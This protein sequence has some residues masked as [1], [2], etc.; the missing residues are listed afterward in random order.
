ME[1]PD[2]RLH[3]PAALRNRDPIL[4][5][6]Q[7]HLP[8]QGHLLE[9][10]SGS[11]EH[12]IY[13]ARALPNYIIQP[14]DQDP[15]ARASIEAWIAASGVPNALPPLA[16]DAAAPNWTSALGNWTPTAILC[17]NMIHISP[18]EATEG[19]FKGAALLL[20]PGQFLFTY[21]PYK[22]EGQHTSESNAR[23]D[24]DLRRENPRWGIRDLES[25]TACAK[26]HGFG[27][28][29]VTQMPANNLTLTFRRL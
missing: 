4:A 18:W 23:F 20:S 11:G 10:A 26:E 2:A 24:A 6:L 9:I 16:L 25:V 13:F 3:A 19:L 1:V 7:A 27:A 22:R 15:K 12:C 28:P 29:E 8:Q 5:I 14:S 17:I 21:G